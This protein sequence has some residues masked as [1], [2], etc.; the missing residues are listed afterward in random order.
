MKNK[1]ELDYNKL[2][3]VCDPKVFK[4]ET[5][6]NLAPITTGIGQDRG[7]KALEFG[8]NVDIKGYNIYLEGPSGVGKTM[9]TKNYLRKIS[10]KKKIPSDWCYI[11]NFNNPNEPI[12][13]SLSAGHGK[14]FKEDMDNFIREIKKD[15]K[16]T[17]SDDDFEKEKSLIEQEF[18]EKR[19]KIMDELEK[20]AGKLDFQVK[21]AKNGIYMMPVLDG[22]ALQEEEFEQLD[23]SIKNQFE[24]KSGR[25]QEMI[26]DVIRKNQANRKT[27]R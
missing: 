14:E 24:E 13:V 19:A 12:A 8:V 4:F 23:E 9:Y 20:E 3:M 2:K 22:K 15:I 11:Y 27:I 16:N 7:I 26:M 5:T 25:V 6:E 1:Y 18:E 10:T 21:A 17:F